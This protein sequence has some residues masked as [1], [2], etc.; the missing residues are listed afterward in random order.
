M[1]RNLWTNKEGQ[2][3]WNPPPARQ[4]R[5]PLPT[6]RE[7]G[8][9]IIIA[10]SADD[11]EIIST[12]EKRVIFFTVFILFLFI[13]IIALLA[14]EEIISS[15]EK[16]GIVFTVLLQFLQLQTKH[17]FSFDVTKSVI[18]KMNI[19]SAKF[20][21]VLLSMWQ[22]LS[23]SPHFLFIYYIFLQLFVS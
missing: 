18:F 2:S 13:I 10:V 6:K 16:R 1:P 19:C 11:G 9:V 17:F 12:I 8:E 4:Y 14:D 15:I 7:G 23:F 3:R 20:R 22:F 5:Q 21:C